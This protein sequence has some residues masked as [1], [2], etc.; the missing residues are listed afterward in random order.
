MIK[1][2]RFLPQLK[3]KKKIPSRMNA[4]ADSFEQNDDDDDNDI[5][6]PSI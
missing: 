2:R 6:G 3:M 5:V 4:I 1:K